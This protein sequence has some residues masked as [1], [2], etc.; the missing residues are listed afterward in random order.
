MDF[1]EEYGA[2]D[3]RYE[4]LFKVLVIALLASLVGG[5]LYYVFF[6]NWREE[7]QVREFLGMIQEGQYEAAYELW[8]CKPAKPCQYYP[9]KEFLEDWGPDSAVGKMN[10]YN[11]GRSYRQKTGVIIT[12][13]INGKPRPNLWVE[14]E[15]KV[16]GFSPY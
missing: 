1:L 13:E 8:G 9:Y 6:L 14:K 3:V 5:F 16:I 15:S 2:A 4:K 11:L 10:D 7:W 12:L